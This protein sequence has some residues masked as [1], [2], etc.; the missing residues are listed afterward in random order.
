MLAWLI[1]SFPFFY[2]LIIFPNLSSQPFPKRNDCSPAF[3]PSLGGT[4]RSES[5]RTKR[6]GCRG[7]LDRRLQL[8][9]AKVPSTGPNVDQ[10]DLSSRCGK[11]LDGGSGWT[12]MTMC[13]HII[14]IVHISLRYTNRC[15]SI[16]GIIYIYILHLLLDKKPFGYTLDIGLPNPVFQWYIEGLGWNPLLNMYCNNP[17]S[18][19]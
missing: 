1:K 12:T 11:T 3:I 10:L 16:Y 18:H 19:C 14:Y 8:R 4:G 9:N 13:I 2:L 6:L 5:F 17:C 15:N 7:V